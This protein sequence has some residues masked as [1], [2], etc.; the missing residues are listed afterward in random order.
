MGVFHIG[1]SGR[2]SRHGTLW[3]T[4]RR[5]ARSGGSGGSLPLH[6]DGGINLITETGVLDCFVATGSELQRT[7]VTMEAYPSL[8]NACMSV[9]TMPQTRPP[10]THDIQNQF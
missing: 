5:F 4:G 6:C 1:A 7:Q 3:G 9:E 2:S 8:R 10:T